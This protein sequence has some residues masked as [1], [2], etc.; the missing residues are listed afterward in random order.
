MNTTDYIY[1]ILYTGT[2]II[3]IERQYKIEEEISQ[4]CAIQ[5]QQ[6]KSYY[7]Q[8]ET[9]ID[10]YLYERETKDAK[11]NSVNG[12]YNGKIQIG[13]DPMFHL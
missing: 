4:N 10:R 1:C 5:M 9:T 12:E 6:I 11:Y 8:R 7:Y 3:E 13:V 2:Y